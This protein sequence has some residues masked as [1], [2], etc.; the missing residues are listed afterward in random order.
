MRGHK[1]S[2]IMMLTVLRGLLKTGKVL[3]V[4]P[5]AGQHA[6]SWKG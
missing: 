4:I 6:C 5:V 2:K 3:P 1:E